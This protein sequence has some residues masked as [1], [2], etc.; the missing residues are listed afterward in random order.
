M[1]REASECPSGPGEERRAVPRKQQQGWCPSVP[2]PG[3]GL[4]HRLHHAG[5]IFQDKNVFFSD[6]PCE[7][8]K[9]PGLH[10]KTPVSSSQNLARAFV[11]EQNHGAGRW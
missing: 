2:V 3:R 7:P 8:N 6:T 11:A 10:P 1:R 9:K 4:A 5:S